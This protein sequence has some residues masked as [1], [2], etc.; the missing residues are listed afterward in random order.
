VNG[1]IPARDLFRPPPPSGRALV[2]GGGG[3]VG[4]HLI[5]RL[6]AEGWT[7]VASVRPGARPWRLDALGLIGPA[8]LA[9]PPPAGPSPGR[10]HVEV[11]EV[12]LT[13]RAATTSLPADVAP[14]VVFHLAASRSAS[15]AEGRDRTTAV[16]TLSGQWLVDGLPDR[17]RTVVRLGSSTEYAQVDGP[18]DEA[19]PLRPRGF[20]GASKAAGSLLLS[21]VAAE[22]GRQA[23]I[24]R[25]FQVYG[26]LDHAGRFVPSV[27]RAAR[28]GTPLP[29]TG[30]GRRRD[31][32]HVDDVV[33]ACLRAAVAEHLPS[34]QVVNVGTGR[35]VANE[36]LV[37]IAIRVTGRPIAIAPCAHPGRAWD[38]ASWVCDPHLAA[39]LLGWRAV[40]PLEEG[41]ARCWAAGTAEDAETA[42]DDETAEDAG[43]RGTAGDA[44]PEPRAPGPSRA[45]T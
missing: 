27:L 29:L 30:P 5:A 37:A 16:N 19:A 14:D 9:A 38:T 13:D 34:G 35:Q 4:A 2:T 10:G 21:A 8:P 12:D 44:G 42:E 6:V 3:F 25:A 23:I 28:D 33:E 7:V 36:E 43:R 24:L 32:I 20:F 39:D 11:A 41:L 15:D 18:T 45:R 40:I 22:R 31:W 1:P 26:P 17:C